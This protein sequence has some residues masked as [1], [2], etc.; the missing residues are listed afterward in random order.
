VLGRRTT[1]G[2]KGK[3]RSSRFDL[4]SGMTLSNLAAK[5]HL[6]REQ[7]PRRIGRRVRWPPW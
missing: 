7:S 3:M 6:D 5:N 1:L 2:V 4:Y